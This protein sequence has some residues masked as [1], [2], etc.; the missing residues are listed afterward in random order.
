[1]IIDKFTQSSFDLQHDD[2]VST[3]SIRDV[4]LTSILTAEPTSMSI[5]CPACHAFISFPFTGGSDIKGVQ[6]L[7]VVRMALEEAGTK[8]E[9]FKKAKAKIKKLIKAS[10]QSTWVSAID[11]EDEATIIKIKDRREQVQQDQ[12]AA[13]ARWDKEAPAREKAAKKAREDAL[14]AQLQEQID[15]LAARQKEVSDLDKAKKARDALRKQEKEDRIKAEQEASA[16]AE[17]IRQEEEAARIQA[18][19]ADA[20]QK[21]KERA[22]KL[23][24]RKITR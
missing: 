24:T 21:F 2:H 19:Q 1:M 20:A 17:K 18:Q 10:D 3:I 11:D 14:K 13:I 9:R 4:Q 16:A 23:A 22:E 12:Q 8:A 15:A 6:R 7:A 5:E